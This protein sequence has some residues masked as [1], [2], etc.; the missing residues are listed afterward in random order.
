MRGGQG[1]DRLYVDAADTVIDGGAGFDNVHALAGEALN[2]DVA[3]ANVEWVWGHSG[4]DVLDA[5]SATARVILYG[6]GNADILTGG[7]GDDTIIG[8]VGDDLINGGFGIDILYGQTDNDTINGG[9]GDD[10]IYGP[11]GQ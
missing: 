9:S 4:M 3:A 2:F 11:A 10:E 8:G 1:D 6:R 7:S 5:S